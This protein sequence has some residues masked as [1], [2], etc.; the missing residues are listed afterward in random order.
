MD[1]GQGVDGWMVGGW[2]GGGRGVWVDA[3]VGE[4]VDG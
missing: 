2:A 3:R 4:W 1:G